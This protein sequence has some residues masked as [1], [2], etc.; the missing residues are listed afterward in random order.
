MSTTT[1][2]RIQ[3]AIVA[4]APTV[5]FLGFAYHPY[6][7]NA[8]DEEA[9]TA[10]VAA[11]TTRW[12]LAHLAIG[13]GY[14]LLALAFIALR[15]YL[16]EAGEER[17]SSLALPFAVLGSALFPILT[18]MELALLATA[19]TGGDVEAAQ[20]ELFPWFVPLLVTGAIS[21]TLGA[22]G[23]AIG[24]A[25]S[26]V[27]G[28]QLTWLAVGAFV[29]MA[30]ARFVPLGAAQIVI[31][32]AALVALWPVAIAMWKHSEVG[33]ADQPRSIPVTERRNAPAG[34]WIRLDRGRRSIA[35]RRTQRRQRC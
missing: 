18:G 1:R 23:F 5:L 28:R 33:P 30:A 27:L 22:V 26:G 17:W 2:A 13:V 11:D 8:T 20:T 21:F 10:A 31:G 3:A 4:V 35:V 14:A 29:V 7:T 12:G 15:S 19:E 34:V 24:I 6:F 16:R 25:R 9:I 32:V